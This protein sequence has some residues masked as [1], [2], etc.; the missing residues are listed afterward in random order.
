MT[1]LPA[2]LLRLYLL[3]AGASPAAQT[4]AEGGVGNEPA[5]GAVGMADSHGDVRAAVLE[6][7]RP[8]EWEPVSR[9]WQ[10]VQSDLGLP[11]P[12]IAVSGRDAYQLWFSLAQPLPAAQARA[13]LELLCGRYLVGMAPGRID[14]WPRADGQHTVPVPSR[15]GG[16]GPW[17]AF[18]APDLAPMFADE[19]WLDLPPNPDGQAQLLAALASI[20]GADLQR[21]M[22]HL[23]PQAETVPEAGAEAGTAAAAAPQPGSPVTPAGGWAD[24]RD[25]LRAVMNDGSV[26]LAL[27]IQAAAAL[28]GPARA[29][30]RA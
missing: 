7:G 10:A 11:A 26:P 24:P 4:D 30:D 25:F 9:L 15:Q 2:E 5:G 1:R 21:A 12:A 17:S 18:V 8:A 19:P 23:Q 22:A 27:R 14:T 16:G 20:A 3:P 6:L 29:S 13:F 28:L